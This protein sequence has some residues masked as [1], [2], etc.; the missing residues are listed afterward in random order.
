[1]ESVFS[2]ILPPGSP[3]EIGRLVTD[4]VSELEPFN[5]PSGVDIRNSRVTLRVSVGVSP[6]G[7]ETDLG[8]KWPVGGSDIRGLPNSSLSSSGLK[9]GERGS[10]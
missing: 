5:V 7:S 10:S 2:G 6:A 9:V 3:S 4:C 1:M 8:D